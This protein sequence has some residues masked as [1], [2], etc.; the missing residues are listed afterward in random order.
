MLTLFTVQGAFSFSKQNFFSTRRVYNFL[1]PPS[2]MERPRV[3]APEKFKSPEEELAYLR[4]RVALKEGELNAMSNRFEKDRIGK[5][6]VAEYG[7]HP[8]ATILHET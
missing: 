5:R 3:A 4:E 6:E 7:E 8:P 1:M 2:T